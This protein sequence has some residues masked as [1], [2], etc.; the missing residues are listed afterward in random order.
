MNIFA[1]LGCGSDAGLLGRAWCNRLTTQKEDVARGASADWS[2][3]CRTV[4][5]ELV[6]ARI[7]PV[8]ALHG[9]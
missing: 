9:S 4:E 3:E 2:F 7:P 1:H 8:M 6:V 5:W